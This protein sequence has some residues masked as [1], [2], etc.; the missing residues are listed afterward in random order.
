MLTLA[1]GEVEHLSVGGEQVDLLDAIDGL[2]AE[3]LE[4][5]LQLGVLS[6]GGLVRNLLSLSADTLATRSNLPI[7]SHVK[8]LQRFRT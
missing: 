1:L 2:A 4:S 6:G 5:E 8:S 7:N 3:L